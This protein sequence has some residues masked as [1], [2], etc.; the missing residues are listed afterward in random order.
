MLHFAPVDI[1]HDVTPDTLISTLSTLEKPAIFK[2]LLDAWPVVRAA[3]QGEGALIDYLKACDKG[4]LVEI[5]R[6]APGGNGKLF[7]DAELTGLNFAREKMSLSAALERLRLQKG[8]PDAE[9]IC[10]Q[11]VPLPDYLPRIQEENPLF[12]AGIEAVPRI[13]ISNRSVTQLHFD[14]YENLVCMVGG[15]KRFVLLPPEQLANVYMGPFEATVAGVPTAMVNLE[16]PD[17]TAHPRL[18]EALKAATLADLESGDVLFIPYMWWHHVDSCGEFNVQINHWWNTAGP[19]MGLDAMYA[20]FHA[21][22]VLR[23]LPRQ[24]NLAWKA[25]FDH[26]VFH[27]SDPVT[28][29]LP[30][31]ARG[32][33]GALTKEQRSAIRKYIGKSLQ[34]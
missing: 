33:L 18:K 5:F 2:G 1:R 27:Q 8:L 29:H 19:Q 24:H 26:F 10:I 30:P 6:Q 20:L 23:D 28:D 34:E 17:F 21:M 4:R 16:Q 15:R 25:M 32:I 12:L 14:L 13:W 11:S 3:Q 7:Y 22:L 31:N 9:H